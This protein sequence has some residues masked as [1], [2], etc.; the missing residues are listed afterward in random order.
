MRCNIWVTGMVLA[1]AAAGAAAQNCSCQ[2]AASR[3]NQTALS[4]ALTGRTACAVF[5]TD[6]W[7]EY[8]NA[9]G[10]LLELGNTVGGETVG[11]W[12]IV[13][14]GAN[15]MVRYTYTGGASYDYQVCEEGSGAV[16]SRTYHFCGARNITNARLV[17]GTG[18]CGA[19]FTRP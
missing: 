3:M 19:G 18:A 14:T 6:R 5:S 10:S 17:A 15:A 12:S 7:Q 13:G 11:S 16:E 8:H 4:Q 1:L 9:G 2:S